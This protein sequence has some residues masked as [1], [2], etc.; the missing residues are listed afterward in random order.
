MQAT[1]PNSGTAK[2]NTAGHIKR[3]RVADDFRD[4]S[5]MLEVDHNI[6]TPEFAQQINLE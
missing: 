2:A 5:V 1:Q 3:Y 6:L 4:F